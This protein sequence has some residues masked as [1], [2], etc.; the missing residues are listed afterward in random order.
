ME[1]NSQFSGGSYFLIVTHFKMNLNVIQ[2][3]VQSNGLQI[4]EKKKYRWAFGA[5]V[6]KGYFYI[7]QEL[8]P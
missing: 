2:I 3:K 5:G 1:K 4:E 8:K 7:I 6:K